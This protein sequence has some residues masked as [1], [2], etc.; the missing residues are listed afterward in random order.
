LKNFAENKN[1][2]LTDR[3]FYTKFNALVRDYETSVHYHYALE[4]FCDIYSQ[5]LVFGLL[6]A[7]LDTDT[8]FDEQHLNYLD[9]IPAEYEL[10]HEFL[11]GAYSNRYLPPY[12]KIALVNVGKYLNLIDINAIQKEFNSNDNGRQNI[13][14]YL[15]EEFLKEFDKLCSKDNRKKNGVYY[16]PKEAVDFITKSVNEVIKTNFEKKEG[17]C[18]QDVKVLDFA[19]GTGTF[20]RSVLEQML[21][22]KMD[23]LTKKTLKDKILKDIYGFELLYTPYVIAHTVLTQMLRDK[24][25]V[26][27]SGRGERLTILLTNTLDISQHSISDYMPEMQYEYE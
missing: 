9:N 11:S 8:K 13:A 25:I 6:L 22:E 2:I 27:D 12:I 19:C 23:D 3:K 4:D 18:S 24:G 16:T 1:N 10:M 5:T 17:Y 21:P 20:I 7:R 15:Y 14:V 26:F